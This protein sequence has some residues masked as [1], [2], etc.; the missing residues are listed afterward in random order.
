MVTLLAVVSNSAMAEWV[1]LTST[2]KETYYVNPATI[3][4]KGSIVE[5]WSVMDVK[6]SKLTKLLQGIN[7]IL[8]VG[9]AKTPMSTVTQKG[10]DCKEGQIRVLKYSTYSDNLGGGDPIVINSEIGKW[11]AVVPGSIDESLLEYAC[12]PCFSTGKYSGACR[13]MQ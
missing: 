4:K 7:K 8:S 2:D 6:Q 11:E 10:F 13:G 9:D 5:M 1:E 12:D 3:R